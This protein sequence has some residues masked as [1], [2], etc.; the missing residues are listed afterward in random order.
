MRR[1]MKLAALILVMALLAGCAAEEAPT[2][3]L[4]EPV[5]VQSDMA[6][7]YVGEIYNI[8]HFDASVVAY[9]EELCFEVDG[10]IETINVYPGKWVE[11]GDVLIELDQRETEKRAE[12]LRRELEYAE[13]DN[14]YTDAMTELDIKMLETELRQMQAQGADAKQ[15][16][17][18]ENEIKQKQTDLEQ[19]RLL[20][21]PELKVKREELAGLEA[22]LDKNVL[23]AP[24]SGRIVYE[25]SITQGTHVA[26]YSPVLF[27]ADDNRLSIR[28]EYVTEGRLKSASRL[29]AK[30][31]GREYELA[32]KPID[33]EEYIATVLAGETVMTEYE[34]LGVT[35]GDE[36][37]EAG[38]Y[39]AVCV[40]SGYIPD[41]LLVP[42][43]AVLRDATGR[44]V[45]V[46]EDGER[47][48]RAVKVGM[49]TDALIQITEGLEEGET[50]YVKD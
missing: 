27:L 13:Q 28:S 38:Q 33:Q 8:V 29:Y 45:Y 47:V 34:I 48:K 35:D 26:A 1:E 41:A 19:A 36:A 30:I 46:D 6:T 39:A 5:G 15:I 31:G 24:F 37:P 21:E 11:E 32:G 42:S 17:L 20:R 2:P 4:M 44:Y 7:A 16:A 23:R 14:A 18:K 22:S 12:Q 43:G 25:K 10:D 9:V 49:S 50:V 40:V 3:E